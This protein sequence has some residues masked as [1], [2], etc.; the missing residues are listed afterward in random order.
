MRAAEGL[1]ATVFFLQL[2][3]QSGETVAFA[4]F[5]YVLCSSV[6]RALYTSGQVTAS[7]GRS[8]GP[9]FLFFFA[10]KS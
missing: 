5:V 8:M 9:F 6:D 4:C 7:Q 2:Q 3:W 10:R 1:A